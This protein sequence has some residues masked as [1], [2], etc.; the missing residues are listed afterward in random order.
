ML[1]L[2]RQRS[3]ESLSKGRLQAESGV[4]KGVVGVFLNVREERFSLPNKNRA[5][6]GGYD[7]VSQIHQERKASAV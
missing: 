1:L 6:L 3:V 7:T 4:C 5:E 2:L